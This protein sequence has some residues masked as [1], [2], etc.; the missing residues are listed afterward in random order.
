M[1]PDMIS[2]SLVLGRI[3]EIERKGRS[4]QNFETRIEINPEKKERFIDLLE[5]EEKKT[6][7]S[8]SLPK[9]N[10]D[11]FE[12]SGAKIPGA[13]RN[14]DKSNWDKYITRYAKEYGVDEDLIRAVIQVESAN[15]PNALSYKGAMGLMQL[16]PQT[17]KML[18]VTDAWDPEQNI[19]GGVK[20]LSQ[21][22]DTF[23]GDIVKML[24]GYNAGPGR[25]VQ[26]DGVPPFAETQN[27]VKKILAML[28]DE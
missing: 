6:N 10:I 24:A 23:D 12:T 27:Y 18:G 26:Y 2:M 3:E 4:F 25:V 20:Y 17:A 14:V 8:N 16:M 13:K 1:K 5:T 22:S 21:L 28:Q 15:N 19:R 7:K 9:L 11:S